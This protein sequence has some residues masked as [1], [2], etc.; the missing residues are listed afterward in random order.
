MWPNIASRPRI[1]SRHIA[2]KDGRRT[3]RSYL[4]CPLSR[5]IPR[6]LPLGLL[7]VPGTPKVKICLL[8]RCLISTI[9]IWNIVF[10]GRKRM[11][12]PIHLIVLFPR[13]Q[14]LYSPYC[15]LI[16][17]LLVPLLRGIPPT[18][19]SMKVGI[20]AWT[21]SWKGVITNPNSLDRDR[22]NVVSG[23]SPPHCGTWDSHNGIG[24]GRSSEDEK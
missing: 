8:T 16:A 3:L 9:V 7:L 5:L 4:P 14:F 10:L 17:L 19:L 12:H 2:E 18:P 6:R 22:S 23:A 20:T 1:P 21:D 15:R 24:I 11:V 13:L